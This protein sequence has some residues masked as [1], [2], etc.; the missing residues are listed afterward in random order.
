[1]S[2]L[3]ELTR[4]ELILQLLKLYETVQIQ[5]GQIE[6]QAERI[7]DLEGIVAPQ[8]ERIAYLEEELSK[9]GGDSKPHWVKANKLTKEPGSPRKK[10]TQSFARKS[11]PPTEVVCHAVELCP[12]CGRKLDGGWV[13]WRHQVVDIP[14]CPADVIDHLFIERECGVCG[15]RCVPDSGLVL[16]DVVVGKKSIGVNLMSLIAHLNTVCLVPIAKIRLLLET[17]YGVSISKG[18]IAELLQSVSEVGG[19]EYENLRETIRGSPFVHGDETGW[20]ENGLNGYLWSFS[21]P[22]VRYF[23]YNTSRSGS[24][25]TEVLGEEYLGTVVADFYGGYNVHAGLKQRCWVHFDRDLDALK[26][27]YP[28]DMG[29]SSWVENVLGVYYRAKETVEHDYT[30]NERS[31][32]RSKFEEELLGIAQTYLSAKDTPQHV[33]AKRIDNFLDELFT[34]VEYPEVPSENN[35]AERAIRPAVIARK[36]SGGTRSDKGSK[37]KSILMSLFGT[38]TAQGLNTFEACRQMIVQVN[39]AKLPSATVKILSEN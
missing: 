3:D 13:K 35:A 2:G 19:S 29:V 21:T 30:D 14:I 37:T 4:D 9:H 28:E 25:V 36:V 16:S 34:F 24:V 18:E 23:T 8:A 32:L 11:L 38:W 7:A 26:E 31:C 6:Q 27:K 17:L 1:M 20:R 33:L 12:K 15:K 39:H 5:A 10:R 22:S